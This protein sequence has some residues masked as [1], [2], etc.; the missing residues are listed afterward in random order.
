MNVSYCRF[1]FN[2]DCEYVLTQDF[3]FNNLSGT[4]RV[5]TQNIP[6]GTTGSTCSKAIKI[7]LGNI[8]LVLADETVKVISK[9]PE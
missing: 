2:G 3:C 6:C 9:R 7:F 8:E 4:F 1:N 5:I